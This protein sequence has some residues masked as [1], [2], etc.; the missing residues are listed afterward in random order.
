MFLSLLVVSDLYQN[1]SVYIVSFPVFWYFQFRIQEKYDYKNGWGY[2]P[3]ISK[4]FLSLT[5][6]YSQIPIPSHLSQCGGCT[7][8]H[9][10]AVADQVDDW[11]LKAARP[12]CQVS[13][14]CA[15][16]RAGRV[17][18]TGLLSS[19]NTFSYVI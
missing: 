17:I 10:V 2:F 5:E 12:A 11:R 16:G 9:G 7:T 15:A 1:A 3:I 18:D 6:Q 19:N 13:G 4:P 8:S 14:H